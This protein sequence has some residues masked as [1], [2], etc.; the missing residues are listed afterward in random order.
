MS[1]KTDNLP[2]AYR[3]FSVPPHAFQVREAWVSRHRDGLN[4]ALGRGQSYALGDRPALWVTVARGIDAWIGQALAYRDRF[5]DG[6][7]SD[8]VIGPLWFQQGEALRGMLNLDMGPLDCGSLDA[9]LRE[10]LLAEGWEE[11]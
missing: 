3:L 2:A 1:T 8:Y 5:E 10:T 7:G 6:I 4:K 11:E 9:V